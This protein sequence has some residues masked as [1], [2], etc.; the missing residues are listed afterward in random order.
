MRSSF[1]A[2]LAVE[3]N[4]DTHFSTALSAGA[5]TDGNTVSGFLGIIQQL[6][7]VKLSLGAIDP[8]ITAPLSQHI[9]QTQAGL[10]WDINAR[11]QFSLE[12]GGVVPLA[13][14][15]GDSFF[16]GFSAGVQWS[17]KVG[18]PPEQ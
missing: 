14:E 8:N 7:P 9:I 2:F 15:D 4:R 16:S 17:V 18:Q 3:M 1:R 6:G 10:K 12:A 5:N 11:H 13:R